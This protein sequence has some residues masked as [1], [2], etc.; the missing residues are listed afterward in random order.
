MKEVKTRLAKA[1]I[2]SANRAFGQVRAQAGMELTDFAA[3]LG[4]SLGTAKAVSS[5]VTLCSPE[6]AAKLE[7][8]FGLD[9]RSVLQGKDA[10]DLMGRR[11]TTESYAAWKRLNV[12]NKPEF[13]EIK[14]RTL[15]RIGLLMDAA[16]LGKKE[17]PVLAM[18]EEAIAK[19]FNDL[20]L[21]KE[22]ITAY[23]NLAKSERIP[24]ANSTFDEVKC[25]LKRRMEGK[26]QIL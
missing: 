17:I 22:L 13:T 20:S 15:R 24:L 19:S 1:A 9:R 23:A 21:Q 6:L 25:I 3:E 8:R 7:Y 14:D 16:H 11:Y 2:L 10:R 5:G 18:L 4:V 12:L 26:T